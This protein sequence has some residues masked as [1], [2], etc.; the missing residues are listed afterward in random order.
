[1]GQEKHIKEVEE[2]HERLKGEL[3]FHFKSSKQLIE[4]RQKEQTLVKMKKYGEAEKIKSQADGLEEWE[5][6]NKEKEVN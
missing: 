1:M 3:A 2:L 6:N 4:L 5:R